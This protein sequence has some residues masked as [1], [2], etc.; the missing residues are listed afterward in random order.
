[1]TGCCAWRSAP[2][3]SACCLQLAWAASWLLLTVIPLVGVASVRYIHVGTVSKM[4]PL[5]AGSSAHTGHSM[6]LNDGDRRLSSLG[7][8]CAPRSRRTGQTVHAAALRNHPT[9]TPS[10]LRAARGG[11]ASLSANLEDD[12]A[13]ITRSPLGA[14]QR[15]ASLV[16]TFSTLA[17]ARWPPEGVSS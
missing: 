2:A 8:N 10:T 17:H 16:T 11:T 9:G 4:T 13:T 12:S 7:G 1:L 3:I 15:A 6:R 14:E 5:M